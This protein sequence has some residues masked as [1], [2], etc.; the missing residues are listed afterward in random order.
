MVFSHHGTLCEWGRLSS[1]LD[2]TADDVNIRWLRKPSEMMRPF[3]TG[4]DCVN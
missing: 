4:R 1:W 2:P 3:T